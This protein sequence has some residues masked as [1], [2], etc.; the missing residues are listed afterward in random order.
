VAFK[1]RI[2]IHVWRVQPAL[3]RLISLRLH[4]VSLGLC[5]HQLLITSTV[6]YNSLGLRNLHASMLCE[7]RCFAAAQ[8][9]TRS[10]AVRSFTCGRCMQEIGGLFCYI[11]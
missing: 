7:P 1:A 5:R 8:K 3:P 4:G 9:V 10:F 6:Q 2:F 11:M